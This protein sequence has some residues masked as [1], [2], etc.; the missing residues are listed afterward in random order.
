MT[1]Q[2]LIDL[3]KTHQ[4]M[5]LE[6]EAARKEAEAARKEAEAARKEADRRYDLMLV[7]LSSLNEN[8]RTLTDTLK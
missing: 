8:M 1:H 5:L 4:Y 2:E 6:S 7:Q 3:A